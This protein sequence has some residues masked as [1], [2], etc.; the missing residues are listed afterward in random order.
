LIGAQYSEIAFIKNTTEGLGFVANGY[1]WK[2]GD[3]VIIADIEYPSNVYCWVKLEKLGV[4]VRWV[5]NQQ[6]RIR[7]DEYAR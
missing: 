7:I 6:G 3:N 2:Q 1:P 5:K 4:E